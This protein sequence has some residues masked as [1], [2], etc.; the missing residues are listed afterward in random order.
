MCPGSFVGGGRGISGWP[1]GTAIAA[2]GSARLLQTAVIGG[3]KASVSF[4]PGLQQSLAQ[5]TMAGAA[6]QAVDPLFDKAIEVR[7]NA[8]LHRLESRPES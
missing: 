3:G 8:A 6:M 5:G 7:V 2:A 4:Y 1:S